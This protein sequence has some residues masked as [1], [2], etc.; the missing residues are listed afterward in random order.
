VVWPPVQYLARGRHIGGAV[1]GAAESGGALYSLR[2]MAGHSERTGFSANS[3]LGVS[4]AHRS[5]PQG[6]LH[7]LSTHCSLFVCSCDAHLSGL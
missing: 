1:L 2:L 4:S 6:C 3:A 7:T 5:Q